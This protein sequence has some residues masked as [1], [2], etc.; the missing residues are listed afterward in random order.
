MRSFCNIEIIT[1]T[2]AEY[3]TPLKMIKF[4]RVACVVHLNEVRNLLAN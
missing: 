2:L 3:N 1:A 4:L